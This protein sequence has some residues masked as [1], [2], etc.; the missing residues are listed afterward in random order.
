MISCDY[1][2]ILELFST[3]ATLENFFSLSSQYY[4]IV[5]GSWLLEKRASEGDGAAW[6]A[7]HLPRCSAGNDSLANFHPAVHNLH[8]PCVFWP[9][10]PG[11][12]KWLTRSGQPWLWLST[13]IFHKVQSKQNSLL[14]TWLCWPW[15]HVELHTNNN[16][17]I[18]S[19]L[20]LK[21]DRDQH[22]RTTVYYLVQLRLDPRW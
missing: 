19:S 2:Y 20:L 4:F 5:L 9:H 1:G 11:M 8:E 7:M 12:N 18:T 14:R 17:L 21:K 22:F 6:G 10:G 16:A 15:A 3:K 13:S